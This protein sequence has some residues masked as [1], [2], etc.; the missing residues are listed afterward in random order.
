[1]LLLEK[2]IAQTTDKV[3]LSDYTNGLFGTLPT[4]K[5]V[6]KAIKKG[7]IFVN[8][9]VGQ[10]GTWVVS[11][12][13]IELYDVAETLPKIYE[14]DIPVVFEDE[15]TCLKVKNH[16][17]SRGISTRRYFYPSL[18][19]IHGAFNEPCSESSKRASCILCLPSY[20]D[21]TTE[22]VAHISRLILEVL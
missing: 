19:Q 13:E 4:R 9:I 7:A 18:D 6:K 3:R 12:D 1:M 5:S 2:H 21:L 16:L 10:T 11:G 17:E 15:S 14:L 8:G 22:Q 20:H